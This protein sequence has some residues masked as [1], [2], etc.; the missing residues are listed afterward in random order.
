M[1]R[2]KNSA[3]LY[4]YVKNHIMKLI[5]SGNYPEGSQLPTEYTLMDDLNV[6]RATV[7]TALSQ[8]ENEGVIYK[9]QGIGTF[10]CKREKNAEL[11]PFLSLTLIMNKLELNSTNKVIGEYDVT[12]GDGFLSE[13][14]ENGTKL[15]EI[16]RIRFIEGKPLVADS[17]FIPE[18]IFSKINTS[19]LE[20]DSIT[21]TVLKALGREVCGIKTNSIIRKPTEDEC[22]ALKKSDD[23]DVIEVTQW[24]Y[25]KDCDTPVYC[26][27]FVMPMHILNYP[28]LG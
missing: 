21:S 7:R 20:N 16:K 15:H 19:S 11:M 8:L 25:V 12:S 23:E 24:I 3:T 13:G 5:V 17:N 6:G 22:R 10:V 2:R 9:K 27:D 26:S 18:K 1:S 28:F 14:W 4:S